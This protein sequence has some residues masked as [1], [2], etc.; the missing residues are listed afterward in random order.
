MAVRALGKQI[1]ISPKRVRP[2]LRAL[3]GRPA[4]A[5]IDELRFQPGPTAEQ[6]RKLL[7]SA[8]ANAENNE[9]M[10]PTRLVVVSAFANQSVQARRLRPRSRGRVGRVRRQASHITIVVDEQGD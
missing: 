9:R 10:D 7:R 1:G 2:L 6:T 3:Q 4:L 8:V 5:A